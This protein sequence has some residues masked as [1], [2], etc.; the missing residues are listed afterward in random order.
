MAERKYTS[1]FSALAL[2]YHLALVQQADLD[3][4]QIVEYFDAIRPCHLY[5]IGSRPR[6]TLIPDECNFS[7]T[8]AHLAFGLQVQN[9]TEVIERD[10]LNWIGRDD[11]M[12]ECTY[13]HTFFNIRDSTGVSHRSGKAALLL[14]ECT[15]AHVDALDFK[16]LYVGQSYG[17][18]GERRAPQRLASHSTLQGIYAEAI[19]RSPDQ[20]IWIILAHV[21]SRLLA[22]I[23]GR[24]AAVAT[25]AEDDLHIREVLK[26]SVSEQH[27]INYAEAGLIR[28]FQPE[29]NT[30]FKD[31]FPSPAHSSYAECYDMDLNGIVVEVQTEEIRLQLW[32]DSVK[33]K[34]VHFG[35]FELHDRAERQS[36]FT[37]AHLMED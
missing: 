13:P 21:E 30:V 33:R 35:Q 19:T 10:V 31:T 8:T 17:M 15:S 2:L 4:P 37:L 25:R 20:E 3:A 11:L 6:V 26:R 16:V 7:A 18:G 27:L 34:W 14:A 5:L 12:I 29:Y 1:E 32:S 24:Q 36:M 28:Y 9:R 22:N 23:D